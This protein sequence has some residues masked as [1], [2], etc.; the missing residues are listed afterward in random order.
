MSKQ[1]EF[2]LYLIE[3]YAEYK[4]T[5]AD[6]VLDEWKRKNVIKLIYDMYDI[7]HCER[8]ENAYDDIDDIIRSADKK[9]ALPSEA[10]FS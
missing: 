4:G 5:S 6:K 3:R 9:T 10:G 1:S 2:F 8:L 7:Y